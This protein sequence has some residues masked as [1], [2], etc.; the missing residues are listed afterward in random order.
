MI[1]HESISHEMYQAGICERALTLARRPNPSWNGSN[2]DENAGLARRLEDFTESD[3]FVPMEL[4]SRA[5]GGDVAY[6]G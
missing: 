6:S 5:S 1:V 2:N 3:D 4:S